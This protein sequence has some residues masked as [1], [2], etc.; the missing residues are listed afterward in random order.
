MHSLMDGLRPD[1]IY[2][3]IQVG[4]LP[5]RQ[6]FFCLFCCTFPVSLQMVNFKTPVMLIL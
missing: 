5:H 4:M 3:G 6:N 1:L 2:Q